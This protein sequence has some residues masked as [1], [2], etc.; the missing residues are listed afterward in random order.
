MT[1]RGTQGAPSRC[2]DRSPAPGRERTTACGLETL[3]DQSYS[4]S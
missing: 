3:D 1:D 2:R 4:S